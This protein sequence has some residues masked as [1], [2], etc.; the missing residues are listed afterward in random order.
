MIRSIE[1]VREIAVATRRDFEIGAVSDD[2]IADAITKSFSPYPNRGE[3][4]R[5]TTEQAEKIALGALI[6]IR[7][8]LFPTP[9]SDPTNFPK[10]HCNIATPVLAIRLTDS[11]VLEGNRP[12]IIIGGFGED[13]TALDMTRFYHNQ[14]T[15]LGIGETALGHDTIVDITVDQFGARWPSMYVGPII[16]PWTR[17]PELDQYENI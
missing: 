7:G 2:E 4:D 8:W 13:E 14:H 16:R 9:L 6:S 10:G 11:G 17:E 1:S 15:F 5:N 3:I 12:E